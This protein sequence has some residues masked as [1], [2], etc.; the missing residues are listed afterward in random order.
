MGTPL[1][2]EVT[3]IYFK[4]VPEVAIVVH[5]LR[6]Y[7]REQEGVVHR[8]L[9]VLIKT[10]FFSATSFLTVLS[11]LTEYL[12]VASG[13]HVAAAPPRIPE[14]LIGGADLCRQCQIRLKLGPLP[15]GRPR[16]VGRLYFSS[17]NVLRYPDRSPASR[18]CPSD[19]RKKYN[20]SI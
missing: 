18:K 12:I 15:V 14:V 1:L 8:F 3:A 19:L 10:N 13:C 5:I 16:P 9:A 11:F 2:C 4:A 17:V 7:I 6:H 20:Y